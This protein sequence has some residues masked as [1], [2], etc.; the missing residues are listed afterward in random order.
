MVACC[1]CICVCVG[2]CGE[3]GGCGGCFTPDCSC[4][5]SSGGAYRSEASHENFPDR[6]RRMSLTFVVGKTMLCLY[7]DTDNF[8]KL[9]N[10]TY[11]TT[12]NCYVYQIKK[13]EN[14][15]L[16]RDEERYDELTK[17]YPWHIK[18]LSS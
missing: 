14:T 2:W 18:R 9:R 8:N 12:F 10:E 1:C 11:R 7:G 3:C 4:T 16:Q 17:A 5:H 13:E 6:S 15:L